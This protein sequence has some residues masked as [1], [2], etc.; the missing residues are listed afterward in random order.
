MGREGFSHFWQWINIIQADRTAAFK[1]THTHLRAVVVKEILKLS[2]IAAAMAHRC[3]KE[4]GP[5]PLSRKTLHWGRPGDSGVSVVAL[6]QSSGSLGVWFC[7]GGVGA[8]VVKTTLSS[9]IFYL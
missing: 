2:D 7:S 6:S 4:W 9:Y 1:R 5:M 3:W 8:V